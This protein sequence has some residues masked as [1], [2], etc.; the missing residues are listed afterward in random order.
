VFGR[1]LSACELADL[2]GAP[3]DAVVRV[4]AQGGV[5]RLEMVQ[6]AR[7]GYCGAHVAVRGRR[8]AVLVCGGYRILDQALSEESRL[9]AMVQRQL[10][11]AGRLGMWAVLAVADRGP[12]VYDYC[13]WPRLGFDA[14]LPPLIIRNL[15]CFLR[16]ARRLLDLMQSERGRRWWRRHGVGLNVAFDLRR[17]SPCWNAFYSRLTALPTRRCVK[18]SVRR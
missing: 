6:A 3:D 16:G 2:A 14:P 4:R 15:P 1:A 10:I 18:P 7:Y 8:G 11:A 5:L 17:G 9:L 12:G 13:T